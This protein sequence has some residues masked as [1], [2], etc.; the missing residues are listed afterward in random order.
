MATYSPVNGS[1]LDYTPSDV[2][3]HAEQRC[4]LFVPPSPHVQPAAGWPIVL[5]TTNGD[6]VG[7]TLLSTITHASNAFL[8]ALL[9]MGVAVLSVQVTESKSLGN[10]YAAPL[11]GL[12]LWYQPSHASSNYEDETYPMAEK[13]C[14]YAMQYVRKNAADLGGT[15]VKIN[16]NKIGVNGFSGGAAVWC[17]T[18]FGPDHAEGGP[19][20]LGISSVDTAYGYSTRPQVF[21]CRHSGP[22]FSTYDGTQTGG[23]WNK[24]GQTETPA[25]TM[26]E[27]ETG[28]FS[29]YDIETYGDDALNA[30]GGTKYIF[31]IGGTNVSHDFVEPYQAIETEAHTALHAFICKTK[32][33]GVTTI[34]NQG[35]Q[36][37]FSGAAYTAERA[38]TDLYID[39]AAVA[40][41]YQAKLVAGL[42]GALPIPDASPHSRHVWHAPTRAATVSSGTTS[43][44]NY[45][46]A[47]LP[48]VRRLRG[49]RIFNCNNSNAISNA[50]L[51]TNGTVAAPGTVNFT[52]RPLLNTGCGLH[53]IFIPGQGG[54]IVKRAG[55]VNVTWMAV[56]E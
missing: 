49:V 9:D 46:T 47:V 11:H 45:M 52:V 29:W 42:L 1:P 6:F 41:L 26:S 38:L 55:A 50:L 35:N 51:V 20:A 18:C 4:N 43:D 53:N 54:V 28:P 33:P 8:A 56:E 24:Q 23:H 13:D 25:A 22:V 2:T 37:I 48:N 12:G 39:D 30:A 34:I 19:Y 5:D 3:S 44:A 40:N 16:P 15:G 36:P 14:I 17:W 7:S 32:Y 21:M 27:A 31:A 10:D